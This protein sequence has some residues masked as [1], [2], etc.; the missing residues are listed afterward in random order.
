MASIQS[1]LYEV[2]Y[3]PYK[4]PVLI[5]ALVILFAVISYLI[6]QYVIVPRTQKAQTGNIANA[7]RRGQAVTVFFFSADWCPH[8]KKAHPEWQSFYDRYNNTVVN[9]MTISC[10][11]M[12]CSL[13]AESRPANVNVAMQK[14]KIE[15]FPTVVLLMDTMA[16]TPIEFEGK[17]TETNLSTF[18][19]QTTKT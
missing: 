15:H 9:G 5:I 3:R 11:K 10:M 1:I 16:D 6:Y 4:R 8:C 19:T 14:Y 2:F 13:P 18:L 17:I 7:N 12:D